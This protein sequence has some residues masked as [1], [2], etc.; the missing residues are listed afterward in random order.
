MYKAVHL[1][2]QLQLGFKV[3]LFILFTMLSTRAVP[4]F[5]LLHSNLSTFICSQE[6]VNIQISPSPNPQFQPSHLSETFNS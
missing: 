6:C 3:A 5:T 1:G 2:R 4:L